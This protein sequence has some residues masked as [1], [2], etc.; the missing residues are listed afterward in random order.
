MSRSQIHLQ[1]QEMYTHKMHT[2]ELKK[3][4]ADAE[5]TLQE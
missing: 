3:M 2:V 4:Y 5:V 1:I